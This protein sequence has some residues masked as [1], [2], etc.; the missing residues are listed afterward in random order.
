MMVSCW[1]DTQTQVV[2][3]LQDA[4]GCQVPAK[5]N[6]FLEANE[7]LIA[8]VSPGRYLI[9]SEEEP[10]G[11]T[12]GDNCDADLCTTVE[13]DNSR[14]LFRLTGPMTAHLL[15]KGVAIDLDQA[16]FPVGSMFQSAIHEI[17]LTALCRG[18]DWFDLL[19]YKSYSNS[20]AEWLD[21]AAMEFS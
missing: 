12:L 16:R 8:C 11:S 7:R 3:Q 15:M 10:L 17:G 4:L 1:P 20:F 14:Q 19:V 9:I 2:K 5:P 18:P 6:L 13:L 21:D